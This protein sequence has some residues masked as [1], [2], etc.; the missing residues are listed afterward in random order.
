VSSPP[1]RYGRLYWT[2]LPVGGLIMAWGLL[3]L[4][5]NAASTVPAS[6]LRWFVAGL[7]A[8]DLLL[9]P[10]VS[11]VG[12]ALR[13]LPPALRPATRAALIVSGALALMTVPLLLGYGRASQPGNRSV[14]PGN[15]PLSLAAVLAGV[16][17]CAAAWALAAE[18]RRRARSGGR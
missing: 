5:R 10:A 8:H 7:L 15:Y 2:L 4:L 9:A 1:A 11:A 3:G 17:A 13:R 16:W 18:L 14:L 6:W 12:L